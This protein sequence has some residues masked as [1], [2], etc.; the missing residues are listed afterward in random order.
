MKPFIIVVLV[1]VSFMIG[2]NWNDYRTNSSL[3]TQIKLNEV[4]LEQAE[5]CISTS[6]MIEVEMSEES[7]PT[8]AEKCAT[9]LIS[10]LKKGYKHSGYVGSAF[11][12]LETGEDALLQKIR[13][14]P[15]SLK[16]NPAYKVLMQGLQKELADKFQQ[17]IKPVYLAS[18]KSAV[19]SNLDK[20]EEGL[21][22][23]FSMNSLPVDD[24]YKFKAIDNI[25]SELASRDEFTFDVRQCL[26]VF[27]HP[28]MGWENNIKKDFLALKTCFQRL[29]GLNHD[30]SSLEKHC[31]DK[32]RPL[33]E[34]FAQS[35]ARYS[36][37]CMWSEFA[38]SNT[39]RQ[40]LTETNIRL[41]T[42][43]LFHEQPTS[44]SLIRLSQK[45]EI[46]DIHQEIKAAFQGFQRLNPYRELPTL[47]RRNI[48][49]LLTSHFK[50]QCSGLAHSYADILMN[51]HFNE[52]DRRAISD[53]LDDLTGL[54]STNNSLTKKEWHHNAKL[55]L[56]FLLRLKAD[57]SKEQMLSGYF[58]TAIKTK[59]EEKL[60]E[61]AQAYASEILVQVLDK[62]IT[63]DEAVDELF[64]FGD[65]EPQ[66]KT[67]SHSMGIF[68]QTVMFTTT[69][70]RP[71]SDTQK[72]ASPLVAV[73]KQLARL[74]DTNELKAMFKPKLLSAL[75]SAFKTVVG[76]MLKSDIDVIIKT[77][78]P[79]RKVHN[80]MCGE[81]DDKAQNVA[82]QLVKAI[83]TSIGQSEAVVNISTGDMSRDITFKSILKKY[84]DAAEWAEGY[85]GSEVTAKKWVDEGLAQESSQQ[86]KDRLNAGFG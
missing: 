53:L 77:L 72:P 50:E 61:I 42:E 79:K 30:I 23:D 39:R 78:F 40:Y 82:S 74:R 27:S 21:R 35:F 75:P 60:E 26:G 59:V 19:K 86:T 32:I 84:K 17:Q 7:L 5:I 76:N 1:A 33:F 69:A 80:F 49:A 57:M 3:E 83:Q 6:Q 16:N 31:D 13:S 48:N 46:G 12:F 65:I 63:I 85:T 34:E 43:D 47:Y 81:L 54:K 4:I 51:Q 64:V 45:L 44:E 67:I 22:E 14:L 24:Y 58:H 29:Q 2:H 8:I 28:N 38:T 68:S 73:M 62:Q 9:Q 37:M 25:L 10:A 71:Q 52:I 18:L 55:N 70:K 20:V 36:A 15:S 11:G 66:K 56:Q 41:L